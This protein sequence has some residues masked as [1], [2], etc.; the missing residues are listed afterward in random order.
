MTRSN[1]DAN[2]PSVFIAV[3]V[4]ALAAI[5]AS[6]CATAP[7]AASKKAPG[8]GV[9]DATLGLEKSAVTGVPAPK[10]FPYESKD[11]GDG[12]ALPRAFDSAPPL[13]PHTV[14]GF[15]PI[16][17]ADNACVTCHA[18]D[19]AEPGGSVPIP[20]SHYVDW[21]NAPTVKRAEIAGSRYVCTA[22]HVP[23]TDAKALVANGFR[24]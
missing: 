9:S 6:A 2:A 17:R 13:I 23:Q 21:R 22:C 4:A 3:L 24:P 7:S 18:V 14:D 10:S 19:K 11:P 12:K 8:P 15:L 16:T 5:L 20:A 1:A